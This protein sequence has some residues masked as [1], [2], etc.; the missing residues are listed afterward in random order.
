M[1]LGRTGPHSNYREL[2]DPRRVHGRN[3]PRNVP[4]FTWTTPRGSDIFDPS[5]SYRQILAFFFQI[6]DR[7]VHASPGETLVTS[8][9]LAIFYTAAIRARR[10]HDRGLDA[11]VM[12][13]TVV[14]E[15]C[16]HETSGRASRT[17]AI[18]LQNP[19]V[20]LP[21]SFAPPDAAEP[22]ATHAFTLE[23]D[24][25]HEGISPA[26]IDTL[27][28]GYATIVV[29]ILPHLLVADYTPRAR[30]VGVLRVSHEIAWRQAQASAR[31][32]RDI[33][34][35]TTARVRVGHKDSTGT[36]ST[37]RPARAAMSAVRVQ[38]TIQ[39]VARKLAFLQI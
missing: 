37:I 28:R 34:I 21:L 16:P 8:F 32:P 25:A 17:S 33:D 19:V 5:R 7:D 30:G 29:E 6:H 20:T 39:P 23:A 11:S 35:L 36:S 27:G 10:G 13:R 26:E 3:R 9:G 14:T 22:R 4:E 24:S 31:Q 12:A 2:F 15:S 38:H 18:L 1:L